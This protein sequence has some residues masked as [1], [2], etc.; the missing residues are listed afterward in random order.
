MKLLPTVAALLLAFSAVACS[1]KPVTSDSDPAMANQLRGP[2][3]APLQGKGSLPDD[4]SKP[5]ARGGVADDT[6]KPL[7][8]TARAG[9]GDDSV[10]PLA[11]TAR[12]GTAD[13]GVRPVAPARTSV[14]PPFKPSR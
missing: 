10:K 13:D 1:D 4:G 12:A 11:P 3:P 2:G 14:P 6:I 8:P 9:T 5:V 7:A